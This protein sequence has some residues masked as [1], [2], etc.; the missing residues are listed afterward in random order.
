MWTRGFPTATHCHDGWGSPGG[1]DR[2]ILYGRMRAR[3]G[4]GE[5]P[6]EGEKVVDLFELAKTFAGPFATIIAAGAATGITYVFNSRQ[7][8]VAKDQAVTADAQRKIAAARLNFDLYAKRYV[9]FEIARRLL[10]DVV[11]SGHVDAKEVI[12]FNIETAD[13]P[14]LFEQDVVNYLDELR[15]KILRLKTLQAQEN[16]ADEADEEEKRQRLV[17][18]AADQHLELNRELEIIV[19]KFKPYLKLG[20]I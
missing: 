16:A 7:L 3:R 5:R 8:K 12:N 18:L 11:Q 6:I 17:D 13:A 15:K 14:F 9:V 2:P 20:N 1:A 19:E 10:L 4:R